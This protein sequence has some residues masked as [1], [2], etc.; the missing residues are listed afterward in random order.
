DLLNHLNASQTEVEPRLQMHIATRWGSWQRT[1]G[2]ELR[3]IESV[4]LRDGQLERILDDMRRFL[5]VAKEYRRLGIPHHRGYMFSGA[6]GTGKSTLGR[7]LASDL[8]LA[9]YVLPL[10]DLDNDANLLSCVAE[11][12][13]RSTLLI[14]DID[15]A[16]AARDREDEQGATMSGLLNA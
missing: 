3:P 12:P 10:S 16:S 13:A 14:E 7:S 1:R 4:V 2:A 5:V 9:L 8:D 11:V 6:P 15:V